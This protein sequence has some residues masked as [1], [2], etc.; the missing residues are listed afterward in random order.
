[1]S[2]FGSLPI[3]LQELVLSEAFKQLDTK[4][5]FGVVSLVNHQWRGLA[6][7]NCR[8]LN[9]KVVSRKAAHHLTIWLW[10]HRSAC[11]KA[12]CRATHGVGLTHQLALGAMHSVT[13]R[14][15]I[16][17]ADTLL[18]LTLICC[19]YY[20]SVLLHLHLDWQLQVS[21]WTTATREELLDAIGGSK[22]LLSLSIEDMSIRAHV[23]PLS[24]LKKLT[25]LHLERCDVQGGEVYHLFTMPKLRS[26]QLPSSLKL[27]SCFF[28]LYEF[29]DGLSAHLK[30]L[31][32]L[33][34]SDTTCSELASFPSAL[35]MFPQ[36]QQLQLPCF[37]V[38]PEHFVELAKLPLTSAAL[39]VDTAGSQLETL[40]AWI[41]QRAGGQL[42]LLKVICERTGPPLLA[43]RTAQLLSCL[44]PATQLQ[45]LAIANMDLRSSGSQLAALTQLTF[46]QITSC[47]LDETVICQV[48]S[49]SNLRVL[50]F[51]GT[52]GVHC[53]R[54][55]FQAIANLSQVTNLVLSGLG[56]TEPLAIAGLSSM[57]QL[58]YLS[59]P[60]PMSAAG[61]DALTSLTQ[62]TAL[63]GARLEI[64]TR[65][66]SGSTTREF[67]GPF[68]R[69][70]FAQFFQQLTRLQ[71]LTLTFV[72]Q[73][74]LLSLGEALGLTCLT[75]LRTLL[76]KYEGNA[77]GGAMEV[78]EEVSCALVGW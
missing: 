64:V 35:T 27:D 14:A 48:S 17:L 54:R 59:C 69:P 16:L 11:C 58:Q 67:A 74:L 43:S 53:E 61:L 71:Q 62:L 15:R 46:L 45:L 65:D 7:D 19:P 55:T 18:V 4:H 10:R 68:A 63:H 9:L 66:T 42:Q 22:E 31:T 23:Q 40:P 24:N 60:T 12:S 8:S 50:A 73:S 3:E 32:S 21:G 20:R 72:S 33:H 78:L 26:L 44:S 28:N 70:M 52:T 41:Q 5:Q 56:V 75:R 39:L 57:T 13:H 34:L 25:H 29:F 1:M 49:L 77:E 2:L 47:V 76:V 37:L 6:L 30:Q 38:R 51:M 36:L